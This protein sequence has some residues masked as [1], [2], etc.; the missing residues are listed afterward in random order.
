MKNSILLYT[1]NIVLVF[2]ILNGSFSISM[3]QSFPKEIKEWILSIN[4]QNKQLKTKVAIKD[5]IITKQDTLNSSY[6]KRI[7][8]YERDSVTT[9]IQNSAYRES[10]MVK[11]SI[12][13]S[14]DGIIKDIKRQRNGIG[15]VSVLILLLIVIL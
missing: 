1:R 8:S 3:S 10:S 6:L 12:I 5:S 2:L 7:K 4:E 15:V 14:K 11:D 9:H 13:S